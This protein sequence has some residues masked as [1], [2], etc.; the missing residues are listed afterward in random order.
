MEVFI[1]VLENYNSLQSPLVLEVVFERSFKTL[2]VHIH[3]IVGTHLL[4]DITE[5]SPDL[6]R[7]TGGDPRTVA[8]F[9]L[10]SRFIVD[11]LG[12]G[13]LPQPTEP[14][15]G[16]HSHLH[17]LALHLVQHREEL[18]DVLLDAHRAARCP[19]RRRDRR[20]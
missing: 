12:E 13:R 1:W 11:R 10:C 14:H 4:E 17:R 18:F 6:R 8:E 19:T 20:R 5:D 9:V 7:A 2:A 16:D 15:D 3:G